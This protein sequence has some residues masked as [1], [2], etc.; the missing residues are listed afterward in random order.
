ML[1]KSVLILCFISVFNT[2]SIKAT[3]N[4]DLCNLKISVEN[5]QNTIANYLVLINAKNQLLFDNVRAT[6][7][8]LINL[9]L[10]ISAVYSNEGNH[11]IASILRILI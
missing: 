5:V 11:S 7:N 6:P 10:P 1:L 4:N 3:I 8:G 2:N 9:N